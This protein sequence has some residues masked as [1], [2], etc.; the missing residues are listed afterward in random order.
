MP[1]SS[2]CKCGRD[3]GNILPLHSEDRIVAP[4]PNAE[5]N[6]IEITRGCNYAMMIEGDNRFLPEHKEAITDICSMLTMFDENNV[7]N[8]LTA[9]DLAYENRTR[10]LEKFSVNVECQWK[11]S[12]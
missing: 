8:N 10:A 2:V 12:C 4:F 7:H 11:E 3:C 5:G 9:Y 1:F 6:S